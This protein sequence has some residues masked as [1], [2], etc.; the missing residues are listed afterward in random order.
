MKNSFFI[1]LLLPILFVV[2][3]CKKK[4]YV[5]PTVEIF[6]ISMPSSPLIDVEFDNLGRTGYV[7]SNNAIFK[8][9]DTGKVWRRVSFLDTNIVFLKVCVI[10]SQWVYF[11]AKN[12]LYNKYLTYR[13]TDAGHS[14]MQMNSGTKDFHATEFI[15]ASTGYMEHAGQVYITVDGGNNWTLTNFPASLGTPMDL[16]EFRD[17]NE[18]VALSFANNRIFVT[19][20]SGATWQE[21][22][23]IS[24]PANNF[25]NIKYSRDHKITFALASGS[26]DNGWFW[27][28]DTCHTWTGDKQT[29]VMDEKHPRMEVADLF[30]GSGF[31]A[32][33]HNLFYTNDNGVTWE[34]RYN[35]NGES[36]IETFTEI[37]MVNDKLAF[38]TTK[39]GTLIQIKL[40]NK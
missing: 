38:A 14:F 15:S 24:A 9:T 29:A 19:H 16:I 13:T 10:D 25:R 26:S 12:T 33:D 34:P 21:K 35:Q 37:T 8:T 36:L 2:S 7:I 30:K 4:T 17:I 27:S 6:R 28:T 11:T 20:N 22:T 3:S 32:G 31:G 5:V 40:G 18:G 39:E 1:L 23:S